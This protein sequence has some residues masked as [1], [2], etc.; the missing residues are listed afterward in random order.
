MRD[1]FGRGRG[2]LDDAIE[3]RG[4]YNKCIKWKY[5]SL[6]YGNMASMC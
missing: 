2:E 5:G 3:M 4:F 6:F 1:T